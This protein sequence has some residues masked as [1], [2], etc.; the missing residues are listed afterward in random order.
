MFSAPSRSSLNRFSFPISPAEEL[1]MPLWLSTWSRH[2][3]GAYIP[4]QGF[5]CWLFFC[6]LHNPALHSGRDSFGTSN[7]WGL[8]LWLLDFLIQWLQRVKIG[9]HLSD[10]RTTNTDAPQGCVLSPV[11][12]TNSCTSSPPDRHLI[13][14][15]T[16]P[17]LAGC[18]MTRNTLARSYMTL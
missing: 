11:L 10:I 1:M 16:L 18:M 8:V 13:K 15:L 5:V 9:P 14:L 6:L 3:Q 7:N 2:L 17:W 4:C 12:Y